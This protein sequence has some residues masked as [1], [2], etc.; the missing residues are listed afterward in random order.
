MH[1][2]SVW[3]SDDVADELFTNCSLRTGMMKKMV[4]GRPQPFPIQNTRVRGRPR[5]FGSEFWFDCNDSLTSSVSH[6]I[7]SVS[8]NQES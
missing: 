5:C 4:S 3:S 8:E 7:V 6:Y 2:Y 1:L